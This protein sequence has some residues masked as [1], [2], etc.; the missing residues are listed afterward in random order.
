MRFLILGAGPAGLAFAN[1]L[2]KNREN[3]FLVLEK[4]KEAGGLCRSR[5]VDGYP[6][7]IGGGH[8]LDVKRQKVN[9]FL[10]EFMPLEEWKLFC[11]DSRIRIADMYIHHPFEASIWELPIEMQNKYLDSIKEAGC[12][13]GV[14]KPSLFIDWIKWKLGNEIAS[15]YMI[16]YNKKLFS[17]DLNFLGTY[18]LE[19]LPNV[20][21]EETLESC[22]NKKAYGTQPGH[23]QFYYP[24]K[25][26][27]GEL[28][29]RMGKTLGDKLRCGQKV[30]SIN[31][32]KREVT[33]EDG[34]RYTADHVITTIPWK[35]YENLYEMPAE[36]Q[37]A[38]KELKHS[39]IE[40]RYFPDNVNTKA[41]WIYEP[42]ISLPYH[43][44]LVRHNFCTGSRGYWT[45]T[46]KE[47]INMFKERS[48]FRYM[49]E[50]A[51]PLNTINKPQIMN[52]LLDWIQKSSV[53]GIGR[54]GEHQHY[55][56][57]VTVEKAMHLADKLTG[58]I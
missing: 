57:D 52:T 10:F 41:Q 15:N 23:A 42:D 27:Y 56:S 40:T 22:K 29:H 6:F 16:P 14:E 39:G 32:R 33:T 45:E 38:V 25:H 20:S 51:Y 17:D 53:Y 49:N 46:N 9:E 44:I 19:K 37:N 12:N 30:I 1:R 43:R 26:G 47:R 13:Q 31:F 2:L 50:Y 35:A 48:D 3:S 18:W 11:R 8:F 4:E 54:W 36:L 28:W 58:K 5:L 24:K 34:H 21:Y 7:D 55:N